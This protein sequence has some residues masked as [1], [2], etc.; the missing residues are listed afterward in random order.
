MLLLLLLLA[1]RFSTALPLMMLLR[2]RRSMR[3]FVCVV[4]VAWQP[5]LVGCAVF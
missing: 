5:V 3:R 2:T 4:S 1:A